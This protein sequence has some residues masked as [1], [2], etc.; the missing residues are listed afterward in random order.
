TDEVYL[1][2]FG[3]GIRFQG[4]AKIRIG[5]AELPV[6]FAGAQGTLTGLDQVNVQLPRSLAGRGEVD[7]VLIVDGKMAN[8]VRVNFK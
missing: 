5:D 7:V 8:P 2:L 1:V 6:L 4:T 3:T